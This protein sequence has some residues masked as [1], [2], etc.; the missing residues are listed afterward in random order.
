MLRAE[1]RFSCVYTFSV[2]S[3]NVKETWDPTVA[4][5]HPLGR[6]VNIAQCTCASQGL[7][8]ALQNQT[9]KEI[10]ASTINPV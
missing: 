10:P 8:Q 2:S 4:C 9:G 6:L 1:D 7:Q 5:A 3:F